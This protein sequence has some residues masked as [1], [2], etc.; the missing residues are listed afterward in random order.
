M[1]RALRGIAATYSTIPWFWSNQY[2]LKIQT[3]GLPVGYDQTVVRGEIDEASFAIVYLKQGKVVALDCVNMP[4]D[5]MQGRWLVLAC[6]SI[7]P[8]F[9][10][11]A[12]NRTG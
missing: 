7:D 12:L 3:V 9:L 5:Y 6:A 8:V 2:R 1:P 11:D 4:R 10:S